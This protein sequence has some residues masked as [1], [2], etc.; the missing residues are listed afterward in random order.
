MAGQAIAYHIDK[1]NT[2]FLVNCYLIILNIFNY[3]GSLY[4]IQESFYDPRNFKLTRFYC[5]CKNVNVTLS[6]N[7]DFHTCKEMD[8]TVYNR[9]GTHDIYSEEAMAWRLSQKYSTKRPIEYL[10]LSIHIREVPGSNLG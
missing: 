10:T 7:F 8:L 9:C 5:I 4:I 1:I 3:K 6:T 2:I